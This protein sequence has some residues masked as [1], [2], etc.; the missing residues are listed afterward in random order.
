M[1]ADYDQIGNPGERVTVLDMAEDRVVVQVRYSR[2]ALST[3]DCS[4][5]EGE[6]ALADLDVA[7]ARKLAVALL[8]AATELEQQEWN[9]R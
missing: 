9:R 4:L 3:Y 7:G 5:P 8:K 1:T 6:W 2:V